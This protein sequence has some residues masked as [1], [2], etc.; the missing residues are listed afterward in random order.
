MTASHAR[1][2][3]AKQPANSAVTFDVSRCSASIGPLINRLS[4]IQSAYESHL[5]P[6]RHRKGYQKLAKAWPLEEGT[7]ATRSQTDEKKVP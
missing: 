7:A 6:K 5:F 2:I 4:Q 1:K 3:K